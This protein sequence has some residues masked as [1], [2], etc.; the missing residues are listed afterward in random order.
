[1]FSVSP[2]LG[3]AGASLGLWSF[4]SSSHQDSVP[5]WVDSERRGALWISTSGAGVGCAGG[6]GL[7]PENAHPGPFTSS[8]LGQEPGAVGKSSGGEGRRGGLCGLQGPQLPSEEHLQAALGDRAHFGSFCAALKYA[9][10]LSGFAGSALQLPVFL[11][12]R[13]SSPDSSYQ[14]EDAASPGTEQPRG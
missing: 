14:A 8:P 6:R 11:T 10:V 5:S 2:G 7:A 12:A 9:T 1:M 13:P 3:L 4:P